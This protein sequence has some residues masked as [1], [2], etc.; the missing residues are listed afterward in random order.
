MQMNSM[1]RHKSAGDITVNC[2]NPGPVHTDVMR[3]PDGCFKCMSCLMFNCCC[4]C[5]KVIVHTHMPIH[6]NEIFVTD[7]KWYFLFVCIVPVNNFSVMLGHRF[8]GIF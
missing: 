2:I 7:K 6:N 3:D 5:G 4:C 8:L 1:V